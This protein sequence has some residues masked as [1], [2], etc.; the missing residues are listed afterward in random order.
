MESQ[1]MLIKQKMAPVHKKQKK[2]ILYL[3]PLF[4][5]LIFVVLLLLVLKT[6]KKVKKDSNLNVLLVTLDTTR[7]DR[8]GCYGYAK[9]K[10]PNLDFLALNGVRFSNAYCQ[11]PLTLPSHCSILTGTYPIYHKVHNNGSYYLSRSHVT[12]AEILKERG[13]KTAAFVSS[14]TVDSR[15]G[16]DQ[17]FEVYNDKFQEDEVI[18]TYR[19]ERRADRVFSSFSSW[20]DKNAKKKF[21]CWVHFY[22]PHLPY[23]PPSPFKEEFSDNPYDG[24]I[25]FMDLYVGQAVEK[26]WR[27]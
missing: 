27:K 17:G 3:V 19:S 18:K 23:D 22:D 6:Q 10:T 2:I 24:E 20:V 12:L 15:F 14:F 9:A 5:I 13:Y 11:V 21:L 1:L 7:A 16:L 4:V 25:A 8:I 26:P